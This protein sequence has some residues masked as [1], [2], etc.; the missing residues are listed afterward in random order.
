[1]KDQNTFSIVLLIQAECNLYSTSL[2]CGSVQGQV[3]HSKNRLSAHFFHKGLVHFCL[4][5]YRRNYKLRARSKFAACTDALCLCLQLHRLVR[6]IGAVRFC[7]SVILSRLL[8]IRVRS[9]LACARLLGIR[10]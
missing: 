5:P 8:C 2:F 9:F 7:L 3:K 4:F 10:L 1:M 6:F